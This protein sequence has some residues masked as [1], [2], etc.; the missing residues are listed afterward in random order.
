MKFFK[1]CILMLLSLLM[2]MGQRHSRIIR[3][4]F[5]ESS[6]DGAYKW[7][8]QTDENIFHEQRGYINGDAGLLVEGQYQYTAPDGQV[9]NV[10]Y[11]ADENGFHA[12]GAHIPT[13]PPIPPAIQRALDYLATLP[14]PTDH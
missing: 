2:V 8:I 11:R 12:E 13:P 1:E 7:A 9:I 5:V 14:P 6:P 4:D 3:N 10:L